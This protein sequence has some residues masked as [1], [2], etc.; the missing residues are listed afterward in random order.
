MGFE[1]ERYTNSLPQRKQCY[2]IFSTRERKGFKLVAKRTEARPFLTH[3]EGGRGR[4]CEGRD[5]PRRR[6]RRKKG[7]PSNL[8]NKRRPSFQGK[9]HPSFSKYWTWSKTERLNCSQ[10]PSLPHIRAARRRGN[11]KQM[12]WRKCSNISLSSL[13]RCQGLF[14]LSPWKTPRHSLQG[15]MKDEYKELIWNQSRPVFLDCFRNPSILMNLFSKQRR[16]FWGEF[17]LSQLH[18][19]PCSVELSCPPALCKTLWTSQSLKRA[20]LAE[21]A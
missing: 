17:H 13:K 7:Q 10:G 15:W 19:V 2:Q 21:P 5:R 8:Q 20:K 18:N 12:Q 16:S 11:G 4:G 9:A 6:E 14:V 1:E 3:R